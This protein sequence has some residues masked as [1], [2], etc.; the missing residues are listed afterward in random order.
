[1]KS[2]ISFITVLSLY[3]CGQNS[4]DYKFNASPAASRDGLLNSF[5][6]ALSKADS[7]EQS[8]QSGDE[9]ASIL[10]ETQL[11]ILNVSDNKSLGVVGEKDLGIC[12]MLSPGKPFVEA[13]LPTGVL[14]SEGAKVAYSEDEGLVAE[15]CQ[16]FFRK[17]M[18][19][20]FNQEF[21]NLQISFYSMT[22]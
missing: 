5:Q 3:S 13:D 20:L 8:E 14:M 4:F 11:Q 17:K 19:G 6:G 22:H 2:I 1:M 12:L 9:L 10:F 16:D 7:I 18:P 15:S 21:F